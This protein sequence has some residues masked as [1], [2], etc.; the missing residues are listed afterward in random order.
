[1]YVITA[2]FTNPQLIC[3]G[4]RP[5]PEY[6]GDQL[7]LQTGPQSFNTT[8]I[9]FKQEDLEGTDW[10]R[11]GCF[12]AMGEFMTYNSHEVTI[13]LMTCVT[14]SKDPACPVPYN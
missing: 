4:S 7:L 9:P 6:L 14:V 5:S 8:T 11:G 10:V 2:Y 3:S 13:R 12:P 1:M